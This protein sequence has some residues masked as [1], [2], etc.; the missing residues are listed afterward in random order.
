[1]TSQSVL[2]AFGFGIIEI[3][4]KDRRVDCRIVGFALTLAAD[5][6]LNVHATCTGIRHDMPIMELFMHVRVVHLTGNCRRFIKIK[7]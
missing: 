2:A 7:V 5:R 6:T 1:M 4:G 3:S